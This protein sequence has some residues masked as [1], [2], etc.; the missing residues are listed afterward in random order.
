MTKQAMGIPCLD[1][2]ERC[3]PTTY[4]LS[5]AQKPIVS[6]LGDRIANT[7]ELPTGCNAVVLIAMYDGWNIED[8]LVINRA[9]V[10]RGIVNFFKKK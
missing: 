10:D 1:F 9:S 4:V 3:D 2:V 5:Y 8:A 6:T 7:V